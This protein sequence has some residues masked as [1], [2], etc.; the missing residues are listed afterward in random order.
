M[1]KLFSSFHKPVVLLFSIYVKLKFQFQGAKKRGSH[2]LTEWI[3]DI[4][5]HFW[6]CA[7]NCDQDEDIFL[8]YFIKSWTYPKREF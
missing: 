3:P 6:H 7:K 2:V 8:E 5:N 1:F 4:Y